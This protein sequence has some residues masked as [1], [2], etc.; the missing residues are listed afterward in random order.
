MFKNVYFC[1][2]LPRVQAM[3]NKTPQKAHARSMPSQL[4]QNK[5]EFREQDAPCECSKNEKKIKKNTMV[6]DNST[7]Q[8]KYNS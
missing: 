1:G 4:E 3:L 8:Q 7:H 5:L 6:V 2:L